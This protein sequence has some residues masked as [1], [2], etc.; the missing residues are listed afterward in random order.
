MAKNEVSLLQLNARDLEQE[1]TWFAHL[2]DARLKKY[3]E[4]D[5]AAPEV[6]EITPPDLEESDSP[7]ARFIQHRTCGAGAQ[8]DPAHPAAAVGH[9][10]PQE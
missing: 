9:L 2:L 6:F 7:Y 1:L 10:L 4:Q 5:A 8:P 3:F